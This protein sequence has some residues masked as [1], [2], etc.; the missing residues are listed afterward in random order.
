MYRIALPRTWT[1]LGDGR[2]VLVLVPVVAVLLVGSFVVVGIVS[3]ID[4][5]AVAE[6][7]VVHVVA[8]VVLVPVVVVVVINV[9]FM[10]GSSAQCRMP[11]T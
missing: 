10:D 11:V 1:I 8:L 6:P 2:V 9:I 4:A 7:L 5:V 3:W